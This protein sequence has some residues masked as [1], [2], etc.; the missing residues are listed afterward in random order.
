M[1]IKDR[2]VEQGKKITT[3]G[4]FVRLVSND[5]VMRVATGIMDAR[6]RL[7]EAGEHASQAWSILLNGH[8]LP[9]IDPALEGEPDV[10]GYRSTNGVSVLSQYSKGS[11][12]STPR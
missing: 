11:S 5:R 2:L 7:R 10:T 6:G 3:S 1:G 4:T 12:P 9:T 8:A